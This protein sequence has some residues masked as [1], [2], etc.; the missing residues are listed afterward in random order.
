MN[1]DEEFSSKDL[2]EISIEKELFSEN[3]RSR[4]GLKM[5]KLLT[6]I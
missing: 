4:K 6:H 3:I 1:N 5:S 2:E